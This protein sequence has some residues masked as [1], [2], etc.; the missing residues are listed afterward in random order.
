MAAPPKKKTPPPV[1]ITPVKA[2]ADKWYGLICAIL[3]FLLYANTL[4]HDYTVDDGTVIQNN[5]ITKKGISALPEIFTTSYRAGYWDRKEGLYRPLSVAMFAIEYEIAP[6]K[7]LLGHVVN[8]LLYILTAWFLFRFLRKLLHNQHPIIPF[9]ITLLYIAHPLHTEVVANIKSRD[10]ILCFLFAV[11]SM[12]A[13]ITWI[14]TDKRSALISGAFLYFMALLSKESAITLIPVFPLIAYFC[15]DKPVKFLSTSIFTF[16]AAGIVFIAIRYA[17]IG[18]ITS[19]YELQLINN[20]IVAAKDFSE[21]FGTAI[22]ILGKYLFLFVA[23][24]TLVFDYSYNTIPIS[25]LFSGQALLSLIIYIILITL[26]V[27][28]IREKQMYAFGILFFG[29]TI[30]L[31]SN[32]LFLIEA[33]MAER[34][35]YMPSLGL[36]IAV[37]MGAVSLSKKF[38]IAEGSLV[39]MLTGNSVLLLFSVAILLFSG[40]TIAR[41]SDWKDNLTLLSADVKSSPNSARIRYAYGSALLIEQALKEDEENKKQAYLQQS[42]VQLEKGV[43][44]IEDYADA[45]YHLGIAYKETNDAVNAIRCFEKSRSYKPFKDAE[46]YIAVGLAYG[47]VNQFDKAIED[48]NRAIALDPNSSEAYN[49]LGLYYNDKGNTKESLDA[50]QKAVSLKPDFSKAW[51]NMGNTYAKSGDYRTAI[52]R[53]QKAI[54]LDGTYGDAYNNIG[55]CYATMNQT[56]SARIFYEKAVEIDPSNV[57]AVINV[58]VIRNQ[59]GDTAGARMWFEKARALGAA[60]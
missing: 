14:Q 30:S 48:L 8:V 10:E 41:N 9:I 35:L 17:V 24:I 29:I 6:G 60:I 59:M 22:T 23:P 33:T 31:V 7:P 21:R 36:C 20:S 32:L 11:L 50:L 43:S 55:N 57:K 27:K 49:N 53:Y 18:V 28:G 34:F 52:T 56:D 15:S 26:A 13:V 12:S 51:Y 19:N 1:A 54:S 5:K 37:V 16:L 45:W 39:K 46:S 44:L 4:G 58:G 38:K 2:L 3:A 40:R 42:I 47:M 25:S